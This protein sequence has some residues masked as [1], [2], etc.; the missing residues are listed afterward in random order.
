MLKEAVKQKESLA[1]PA[2]SPQGPCEFM[3]EETV[4]KEESSVHAVSGPHDPCEFELEEAVK[5][6]GNPFYAASGPQ[7]EVMPEKSAKQK[8]QHKLSQYALR[9]LKIRDTWTAVPDA[10]I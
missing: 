8:E 7:G 4:K 10:E 5:Q 9:T 2:F 1:D 6:K 3:L